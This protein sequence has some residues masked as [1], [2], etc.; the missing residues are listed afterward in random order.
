MWAQTDDLPLWTGE[1]LAQGRLLIWSEQGIGD[2]IMFASLLPE[3]LDQGVR[4]VLLCDSRLQP[5]L[6]RSFPQLEVLQEFSKANVK[7]LDIKAHTPS[8]R[9]PSF[10]RTSIESFKRGGSPYLSAEPLKIEVFRKSYTTGKLRIGLAWF[11]NN[12]ETG[13]SRSIALSQFAP[14][15]ELPEIQWISLQYGNHDSLEQEASEAKAPIF[16]D[17][18]VN[19]L[20][21]L[22]TFAA[23]IAAMDL[24]IT[25][26]N[27]TAH[28]AGALGV[29][30]WLMLPFSPDWR[31]QQHGEHCLWYS[32]VFLLRQTT[33]G[34][35]FS[36]VQRA[37]T[38]LRQW[39][40][41]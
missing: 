22:D 36:V 6:Q 23:Q 41:A 32:S 30:T 19:Q 7:K 18:S 37:H 3:I 34:D 28:L 8:G 5:L 24:V 35:W 17:R 15:F 29:P 9:L 38:S 13:W 2:E 21:D 39:V 14:L 4:C 16:I 27:S 33:P 20:Q 40:S 31:W 12:Q 26:D 11:T 1:S 10:S 25:I